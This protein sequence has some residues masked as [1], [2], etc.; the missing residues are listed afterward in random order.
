MDMAF[1]S[2]CRTIHIDFDVLCIKDCV[3]FEGIFD[4]LLYVRRVD[5][6]HHG[7]LIPDP[8]NADQV[9]HGVLSCGSLIPKKKLGVLEGETND[10]GFV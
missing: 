1:Q 8:S 2:D 6:G 9:S 4:L 5:V 7:D 3:S 10:H